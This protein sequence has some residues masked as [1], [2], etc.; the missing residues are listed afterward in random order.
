VAFQEVEVELGGQD[1]SRC[2]YS[3]HLKHGGARVSVPA[4]LTEKLGWGT[5]TRLRLLVGSG[6]MEG[7][8][9]LEAVAVGKITC[10]PALKSGGLL[11]RLGRFK[12]LPERPVEGLRVD[13]EIGG[14]AKNLH[15]NVTW[16]QLK[17]PDHARLVAPMPRQ[18]A[19]LG[20]G[21][22]P[23]RDAGE[24]RPPNQAGGG[25]PVERLPP[26]YNGSRR[27][28]TERIAGKDGNRIGMASGTRGGG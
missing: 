3:V 21:H 22:Q 28:V 23:T 17:I 25:M 26:T 6:D 20:G 11:I 4:A 15:S 16:M 5:S 24:K 10:R 18:T 8:L 19:N 2:K 27:D 12:G 9:R 7:I 1:L 13:T 14:D